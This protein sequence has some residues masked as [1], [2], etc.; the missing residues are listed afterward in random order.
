[1]SEALKAPRQTTVDGRPVLSL[2][3]AVNY[4]ISGLDVRVYHVTNV[5]IH[6]AAAVA[7]CSIVRRILLSNCLRDRWGKHADSIALSAALLWEVHPLCTQAVTYV[8]QRAESMM[9]LFYLLTI[10]FA[11]RSFEDPKPRLWRVAAV[12]A[13]ALAMGTKEVAVSAPV[14]VWLIDR[15]L[16]ARAF[17]EAIRRRPIFYAALGATM[18][19]QIALLLGSPR[20]DV[21]GFGVGRQQP[22]VYLATQFGV[23]VHYLRLTFWPDPLCIDYY[24]PLA[25][26]AAEI[27][28]PM[29]AV[30]ALFFASLW[31][32]VR[33]SV[34]GI[35]GAAF[36]MILAPTSSVLPMLDPIFEHRFYLPLA[37][38]CVSSICL[39][40]L[41]INRWRPAIPQMTA[42]VTVL[43][44]AAILGTMTLRRNHDYRSDLAL[45]E[46]TL[47]KQPKNTR[48]MV[49]VGIAHLLEDRP[50]DA[51]GILSRAVDAKP[52]YAEARQNL[53]SAL[54]KL[55][56]Y[57][58]AIPHYE[59]SLKNSRN[60]YQ[61]H[62]NLALV[63]EAVGRPDDAVRHYE[64]ALRIYPEYPE[65]N[66][67][68]AR[69]LARNGMIDEA[70]TRYLTV[71]RHNPEN[72]IA[73]NAIGNLHARVGRWREAVAQYRAALAIQPD[74]LE[75]TNNLGIT[76][77][78]LGETDEATRIFTTALSEHPDNASLHANLGLTYLKAGNDAGAQQAF[79]SALRI[80]P[81]SI[82]A[83]RGMQQLRRK[84]QS[85]GKSV[86][87]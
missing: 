77:A 61:A 73:R 17:G 3:L 44:L 23:I 11:I 34:W 27:I 83:Q 20:P 54:T 53:A 39:A 78:R 26:S 79:E 82:A 8:I 7:L 57:E 5:L 72:A 15:T 63:L 16:Y 69:M 41:A 12:G 30:G 37:V 50:A 10:Y 51:V 70:I 67:K 74:F 86:L 46:D 25:T 19:I 14:L 6:L 80:D 4:A 47:A 43:A 31:A 66:E 71:L 87:P 55:G 62:F 38:V 45:W 40:A 49:N 76:L 32:V 84:D 18:G 2:S 21:E 56:R 1:M 75:A 81:D 33:K 24:W 22:L 60:Y 85:Q 68:Y 52:D 64:E 35:A 48:A 42:A 9:A 36:F 13:C 28:P 58:E 59:A 29:I 65:A